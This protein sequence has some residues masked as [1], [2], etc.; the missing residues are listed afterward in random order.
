MRKPSPYP[1]A[2]D[3]VAPVELVE[4][5]EGLK[6]NW[7]TGRMTVSGIGVPGDRGN[8]AYRRALSSRA[9]T[10]DA[11]RRFA[12]ALDMVRVDTNTRVKDLAVVDDTLRTRLSDFVKSAK[13]LETN[14]WPDGSAEVVLGADLRGTP[15]LAALITKNA[16]PQPAG[17][18]APSPQPE[19]VPSSAGGSQKE[20]V[21]EPVPIRAS[22]SSLIIE[23]KGLGAQPAI[24]PGVRD[25]SGKVIELTVGTSHRPV[26]YL[27]EGAFLDNAAGLNP[28][29]LTASR[30]QGTLRADLVLTPADAKALKTSLLEKKLADDAPIIVVL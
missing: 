23:A 13:V 14:Y 24:M 30:T 10:A 7:S 6:I 11:Y 22:Y 16:A 27:R 9:A 15:S 19:P 20:V 8:M 5:V 18:A 29:K 1:S 25:E 28:L 3:N 21:T 4:D 12:G 26:K 2:G 17:S